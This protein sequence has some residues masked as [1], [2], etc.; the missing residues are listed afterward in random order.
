MWEVHLDT[1]TFPVHTNHTQLC[2]KFFRSPATLSSPVYVN[3]FFPLGS[4]PFQLW[5]SNLFPSLCFFLELFCHMVV[6]WDIN[7]IP[8]EGY[9][10]TQ[11]VNQ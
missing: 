3:I 4:V 2:L 9:S 5:V 10:P 8:L 6:S 11:F 7:H 1:C